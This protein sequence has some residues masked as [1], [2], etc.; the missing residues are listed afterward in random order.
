M[1]VHAN[2]LKR[3][4]ALEQKRKYQTQKNVKSIKRNNNTKD[5]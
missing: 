4:K 3:L 2:E 5:Q 1:R